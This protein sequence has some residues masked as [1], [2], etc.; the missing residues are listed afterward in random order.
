MTQQYYIPAGVETYEDE[1]TYRTK[2]LEYRAYVDR[3]A[4]LRAILNANADA[5]VASWR[6]YGKNAK[7]V[8]DIFD[9]YR[10]NG[11]ETFKLL[12]KNLFITAKIGGDAYAEIIL[13]TADGFDGEI[14]VDLKIL[15]SD[16]IDQV[17]KNGR[18]KRYECNYKGTRWKPEQILHLAYNP[19]GSSTHGNSIIEPMKNILIHFEALMETTNKI[20]EKYVKP[21]NVIYMNTDSSTEMQKLV[22]EWKAAF[23]STAADMF[24]PAD[25][26]QKIDR[27]SVPQYSILDPSNWARVLLNHL[28]MASRVPENVLG[29]GTQNS[30][31]SARLQFAGFRQMVR[32]DQKFMEENMKY[33]V[34]TQLYPENTPTL[35]FSFATEAQEETYERNVRTLQ[36][37]NNFPVPD[38]LKILLSLKI[39][40]EMGLIEGG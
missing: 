38:Q 32:M 30:E 31:E 20:F 23:K 2:F 12:M 7:K 35:K 27:V 3:N 15:P 36:A 13:D 18:I 33:Q 25:V 10:G 24:V 9:E 6:T 22:D 29:I 34:L 1:G 28:L 14:P 11:K 26:V 21:M 17:I 16:R 37:I 40:M 39:L 19:I 4:I 8:A 5:V